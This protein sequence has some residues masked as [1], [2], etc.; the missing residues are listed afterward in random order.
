MKIEENKYYEDR[1]GNIYHIKSIN[2]IGVFPI[3]G[4]CLETLEGECWT[5]T[6]RCFASIQ[7]KNDLIK[8]IYVIEI[9]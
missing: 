7:T 2:N 9:N 5:R 3:Y 1:E 8:E 6:G 4:F